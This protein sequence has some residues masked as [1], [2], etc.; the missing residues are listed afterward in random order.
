MPVT[1]PGKG[2]EM[3]N[4]Q[5]CAFFGF[6]PAGSYTVQLGTGGWVDRQSNVTPSQVVGVTVGTTHSVQFDYD[7]ATAYAVTLTSP[8][9]VPGADGPA[10]DGVLPAA[11]TEWHQGVPGHGI[12]ADPLGPV[13]LPRGLPDLGREA[14]G[15]RSREL[16]RRYPPDGPDAV[17]GVTTATTVRLADVEVTVVDASDSQ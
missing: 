3:T 17:A 14:L 7:E 16:A 15:R 1:I 13:P 12:T 8:L 2:T 11:R 5:G 4:S 6:L 10:V 9:P